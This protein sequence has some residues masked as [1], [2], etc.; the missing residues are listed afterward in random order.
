[1][2]SATVLDLWEAGLSMTPAARAVLL[3]QAVGESDVEEWAAGRRDR[4]LL[5]TYCAARHLEAV[6]DCQECGTTLEVE[7]DPWALDAPGATGQVTVERDGYV[8]VARP[9]TAGDHATLPPD[10]DVAGLRL[11][12][13]EMCLVEASRD[14]APVAAADLPE[15]VVDAIDDALDAADP[16][17]D[18]RLALTCT[19][20]GAAWAGPLD[21]VSFAWSCVEASARRLG[22]D[23]HTLAQ[24]YGWSEQEILALS[25][26]RRHLYLSAVGQ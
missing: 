8:V 17:A 14:G 7:L 6:A 20:C 24:A 18:I 19:E 1:M 16:G 12:L 21:P 5:Q 13:L 10:A 3:L 4:A 22:T 23:V 9:P 2:T 26:F 15:P 25:P 11:A